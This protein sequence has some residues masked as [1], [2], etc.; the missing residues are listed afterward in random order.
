MPG[1]D[2]LP[3]GKETAPLVVEDAAAG[4]VDRARAEV[5]EAERR[6]KQWE[7]SADTATRATP[8]PLTIQPALI[9]GEGAAIILEGVT[10][11]L[12]VGELRNLIYGKMKSKP[13]PDRQLLFIVSGG[14][15]PLED[16]TLPIGAYEVGPEVT[17]H[18]AMQDGAA[19]AARRAARV[20][21]RAEE[22]D[23]WLAGCGIGFLCFILPGPFVACTRQLDEHTEEVRGCAGFI[24]P[25]CDTHTEVQGT[26]VGRR[27]FVDRCGGRWTECAT[28]CHCCIWGFG[29][30]PFWRC[31]PTPIFWYT[32]MFCQAL[33]AMGEGE[34]R[35]GSSPPVPRRR[36]SRCTG[37]VPLYTPVPSASAVGGGWEL[38]MYAGAWIDN[39]EAT[40]ALQFSANP[41]G[42]GELAPHPTS[43]LAKMPH[44]EFDARGYT[45]VLAVDGVGTWA[46]VV[47]QDG[48]RIPASDAFGAATPGYRVTFND[49]HS[50]NT[51]RSPVDRR[52]SDGIGGPFY[53][54]ETN[55]GHMHNF[56][57]MYI[58]SATYPNRGGVTGN[59]PGNI[60]DGRAWQTDRA[61]VLPGHD[62]YQDPALDHYTFGA[63][64]G[65]SIWAWYGR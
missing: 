23:T 53:D 27:T 52:G 14:Q 49:G 33:P 44:E 42:V 50:F 34:Q 25:F 46:L 20:Q 43:G 60:G 59:E 12:E 37:D 21:V 4:A 3:Q 2:I 22:N 38:Y 1:E 29:A 32:Q 61:A 45:E 13:E 31:L 56:M 17:L 11:E 18:L 48:G 26:L 8:F 64:N 19:A 9:G 35:D 62:D 55:S 6:L 28:D 51:A 36:P 63:G 41:G 7:K 58:G 15:E 40:S 30:G 16:E 47:R 54:D 10:A 24:V 5:A 65:I 39:S 57:M